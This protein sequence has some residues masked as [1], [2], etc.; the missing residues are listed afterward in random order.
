MVSLS[1]LLVPGAKSMSGTVISDRRAPPPV[2]SV[3]VLDFGTRLVSSS[4]AGV[5]LLVPGAKSMSGT[6]ISDGRA[7]PPV[8]SVLVLDFGTRLV[9]FSSA[10]VVDLALDWSTTVLCSA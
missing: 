9:S 5:P 7:P 8:S 4:S 6:V 3:L 1:P 2:S 10:G